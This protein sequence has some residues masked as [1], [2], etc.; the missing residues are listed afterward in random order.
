M[1]IN[2]YYSFKLDCN[3][4]SL[5]VPLDASFT[6]EMSDLGSD[7]EASRGPAE[8]AVKRERIEMSHPLQEMWVRSQRGRTESHRD[9]HLPPEKG[10]A[11]VAFGPSTLL[12]PAVGVYNVDREKSSS[13][14]PPL[15]SV[16]KDGHFSPRELA[17]FFSTHRGLTQVWFSFSF[18]CYCEWLCA[19]PFHWMFNLE[20]WCVVFFLF[21]LFYILTS[22][23]IVSFECLRSLT[24]NPPLQISIC[25]SAVPLLQYECIRLQTS[26]I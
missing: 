14:S 8:P 3:A 4:P 12:P 20:W 24:L 16:F 13:V 5:P 17:S 15:V 22:C 2:V 10:D 25:P 1:L 18:C 23:A 7:A 6:D 11:Q 26:D 19:V 9:Q 21:F